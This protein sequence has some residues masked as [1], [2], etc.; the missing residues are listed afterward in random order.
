MFFS[1]WIIFTLTK[2][3]HAVTVWHWHF[4]AVLNVLCS[5]QC[6]Y[7][8]GCCLWLWLVFLPVYR[9]KWQHQACPDEQV[10]G[11]HHRHEPHRQQPP[12]EHA[13]AA[14]HLHQPTQA[15]LQQH[16]RWVTTLSL[17]SAFRRRTEG[18][19]S[20]LPRDPN[21]RLGFFL[22][23]LDPLSPI[24]TASEQRLKA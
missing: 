3:F 11:Q 22:P 5:S 21:Q 15:S 4:V 7:V 23:I 13:A 14:Q 24:K 16:P 18:D 17:H 9:S 6:W 8:P 1:F 20:L 12:A 2:N 10:Q 19:G